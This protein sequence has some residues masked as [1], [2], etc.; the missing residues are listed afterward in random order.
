LMHTKTAITLTILLLL[1]AGFSTAQARHQQ[2]ARGNA[3]FPDYSRNPVLL[4]LWA[5]DD[6]PAKILILKTGPSIA[7][8]LLALL[9]DVV[10]HHETPHFAGELSDGPQEDSRDPGANGGV[11]AQ[12][13]ITQRLIDASVVLLGHMRWAQAAPA[14][15]ELLESEPLSTAEASCRLETGALREI[16]APAVPGLVKALGQAEVIAA[17]LPSGN[18]RTVRARLALALIDIGDPRAIPA[19]EDL[20]EPGGEFEGDKLIGS[21]I[22]KIRGSRRR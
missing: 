11:I 7:P 19:L 6:T 5:E 13:D 3:G 14:I 18:V 1:P 4:G 12:H 16:G 9:K 20:I 8:D 10:E 17:T 2:A 21:A 22:D 15:T